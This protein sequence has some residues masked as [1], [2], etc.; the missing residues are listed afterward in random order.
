MATKY[1]LVTGHHTTGY[2]YAVAADMAV[3]EHSPRRYSV[4]PLSQT[5]PATYADALHQA[6]LDL[7][8]AI[9]RAKFLGVT[10]ED[11]ES[12]T[13]SLLRGSQP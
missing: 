9:E 1:N 2:L 11:I 3:I 7:L 10:V 12:I 6:R 8:D 5:Q 4:L 13:A